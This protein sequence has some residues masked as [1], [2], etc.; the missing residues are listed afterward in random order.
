VSKFKKIAVIGKYPSLEGIEDFHEQLIQL[1][2]HLSKKNVVL[3][4]E[5]KTQK[6]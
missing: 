6:N 3:I 1:I 5:E 4:I 2:E